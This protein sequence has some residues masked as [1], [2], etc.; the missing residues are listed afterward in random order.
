MVGLAV[1]ASWAPE[2]SIP[3]CRRRECWRCESNILP[4]FKAE[5]VAGMLAEKTAG[6]GPRVIADWMPASAVRP[7][8][9]ERCRRRMQKEKRQPPTKLNRVGRYG[10]KPAANALSPWLLVE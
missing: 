2:T 3:G 5:L 6:G 7:G 1:T 10:M 9:D 8:A 4:A